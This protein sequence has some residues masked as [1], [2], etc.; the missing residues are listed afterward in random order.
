VT[1]RGA[2]LHICATCPV[3]KTS[4]LF[5]IS[6]HPYPDA[7]NRAKYIISQDWPGTSIRKNTS[8]R[9]FQRSFIRRN[10]GAISVRIGKNAFFFV[11]G[12][13]LDRAGP[14]INRRAAALWLKECV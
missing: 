7:V 9:V 3:V 8:V 5:C 1:V 13:I 12:E 6:N 11:T 2:T 4:F 14:I 10:W